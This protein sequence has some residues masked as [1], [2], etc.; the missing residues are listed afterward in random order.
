MYALDTSITPIK[1]STL[2]TYPRAE[3]QLL[4]FNFK[5]FQPRC[6]QVHTCHDELVLVHFLQVFLS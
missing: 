2:S 5:L 3:F 1:P 4:I 6:R